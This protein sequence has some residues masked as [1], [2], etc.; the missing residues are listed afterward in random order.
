ML[1]GIGSRL[2]ARRRLPP[3]PSYFPRGGEAGVRPEA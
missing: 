1:S 2:G 3:T